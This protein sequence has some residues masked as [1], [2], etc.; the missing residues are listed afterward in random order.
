MSKFAT[1]N[2]AEE[3]DQPPQYN[4]GRD[5]VLAR[6]NDDTNRR[7]QKHKY[8]IN[9]LFLLL[10]GTWIGLI[11]RDVC[12]HVQSRLQPNSFVLSVN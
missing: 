2:L 3:N 12:Y 1:S 9:T 7:L 6:T 10:I 4:S 11:I 8:C 5:L